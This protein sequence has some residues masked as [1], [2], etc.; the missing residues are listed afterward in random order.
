MGV[1]T[2]RLSGQDRHFCIDSEYKLTLVD[3]S[4]GLQ[5]AFLAIDV[6]N[7]ELFPRASVVWERLPFLSSTPSR[8][9]LGSR[10]VRVFLRCADEDVEL[11]RVQSAPDGVDAVVSAT[12]EVTIKLTDDAPDIID[13]VVEVETTAEG[14][15]PLKIPVVRYAPRVATKAKDEARM[16]DD[17]FAGS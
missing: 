12:H 11:F 10:G 5:K 3:R 9:I 8:A 16:P 15:G 17:P 14:R 1:R 7:S 13:G 4:P 2:I 6:D